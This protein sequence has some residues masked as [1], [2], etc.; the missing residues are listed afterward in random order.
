MRSATPDTAPST[1][2][3]RP[4]RPP[5][6]RIL[7]I[8]VE[9]TERPQ[10]VVWKYAL[11]DGK[12]T[13]IPH[14]PESPRREAR[15]NDPSTWA[16][17]D[18]AWGAYE[19]GGF[20]G[21]G[22]V[23]S[24]DDP[25]FGVD[26]DRCLDG[27]DVADW[28]AP[29]IARMEG[30]F[31]DVSP[32]NTGVKFIARGKLP[33]DT[34]TRRGGMGPD[35][36]G[37]LELYDYRRF[38]TIT[39]NTWDDSGIADRQR[40][41][42]DL[43][44]IAKERPT[45][46]NKVTRA[47]ARKATSTPPAASSNGGHD[48][49]EVLRVASRV[50]GF[51]ALY[52]GDLNGNPSSSEA[53]LALMSRLAFVCGPGQEEQ[54]KRLFIGS[55][56]G[57]RDKAGRDD[58][59]DRTAAR[60]YENRL[61]YFDWNR[62]PDGQAA[63][64]FSG[65]EPRPITIDL[66]PVPA[67]DPRMI[68]PPFRGWCR[69][70]ATRVCCP[71][72]YVAATLIVVIS[73]LIGRRV[74]IRPKR[75]DD[76]Q[77]IPNLWGAVVGRPGWLKTPAVD[78]IMRP[79]KRL[80]ADAFDEHAAAMARWREAALV[81]SARKAA[82]V[83]ELEQAAKRK[84]DDEALRKLARAAAGEEQ[85]P[86]PRPARYVINDCTIEKC[87]ELL[88]DNPNGLLMFRD[89]L[90]GFLKSFERQGHEGDRAFYLEGWNGNGSYEF[91]R[92]VRGSTH[93]KGLCLSVFGS[94]QPGPL[95]RYLR[96]A[97]GGEDCDGF[98]PRFQVMMYPDPVA[99]FVNVDEYPNAKSRDLAYG[100]FKAIAG[101]D[102]VAKGCTIE[103]DGLLPYVRFDGKAQ[104]FFDEWRTDLEN[105]LRHGALSDVM[106]AHLSKFRSLMPSLALWT[107]IVHRHAEASLG[108]VPLAAASAAAAWCDLL[109]A[110][111][112][113]I[114]HS[115]M[116]GTVDD[117]A[118]L[119]E[120]I[121]ESLPNPFTCRLVAQ[122]GWTGLGT[123]DEARRAVGILE[124]RGWVKVVEI[125]SPDPMGRGRPAELVWINPKLRGRGGPDA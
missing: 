4:D 63:P 123:I 87:G 26:F 3:P 93:V 67:L 105:R 65:V 24:A 66:L 77:V 103:D 39:G 58:Y 84:L 5:P 125:P 117:A 79:L 1:P 53:D 92:I 110:H 64:D 50:S 115:A 97:F 36:T 104:G 47:S 75:R 44:A 40:A 56:L 41:A 74:A 25:Y 19:T 94:I 35:G 11:R 96:S 116:E 83:K 10:W 32:S 109:E 86:E 18:G 70:I 114:Y 28:A 91:D 12:W 95:G 76:W 15:S 55:R 101:F 22:Y 54:V 21:I 72:E 120:R 124:D 57:K 69:D 43:Y 48:D 112:R 111:A 68:P 13:K 108:P 99:E 45:G 61:K 31:G 113:R 107:H 82:A 52:G 9:L 80:V 30:T 49:R 8:P 81:A 2:P 20:D 6:P 118:R 46:P 42:D 27:H 17:F 59:L 29:L 100:V 98:I 34:G 37:A 85:E 62:P 88:V 102:A 90:V 78:E 60:A 33:A 122:K 7:A 38:F 106:S 16:T 71:L 23:F 119:A 14:Q 51:D 73:G 89:E 121:Q